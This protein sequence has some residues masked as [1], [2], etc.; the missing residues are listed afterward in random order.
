MYY[1]SINFKS[2]VQN[3]DRIHSFILS[4]Y[5]NMTQVMN[6]KYKETL[7][8]IIIVDKKNAF[9]YSI[10]MNIREKSFQTHCR[11]KKKKKKKKKKWKKF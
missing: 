10:L 8:F 4:L 6:M 2:D 3:Q 11:K 7:L 9:V 1:S 5:F